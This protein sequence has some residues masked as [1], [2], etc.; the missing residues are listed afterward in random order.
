MVAEASA[1]RRR[2]LRPAGAPASGRAR[3]WSAARCDGERA[4]GRGRARR[5]RAVRARATACTPRPRTGGTWPACS[6]ARRAPGAGLRRWRPRE[7]A[8]A[9]RQRPARARA[10]SRSG[11]CCSDFLRHDLG[12]RGTH[13][14]CEHGVCGACTVQ[15]RRRARCA[16]A[17]CSPS[18]PTAAASRRSRALAAAGPADAAAGGVPA[19]PRPAVRLLHGRAS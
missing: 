7:R 8:R 12:L 2:G 19:P 17:C 3:C 9:H 18:R 5:A 14:G 13:V 6:P 10:T 16:R 11:A 15:P 1:R 4:R